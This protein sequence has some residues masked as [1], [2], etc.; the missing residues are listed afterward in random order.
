MPT[1]NRLSHLARLDSG[2]EI[3]LFIPRT[4]VIRN[5]T[6]TV[7]TT[8]TEEQ[9]KAYSVCTRLTQRNANVLRMY[10]VMYILYADASATLGQRITEG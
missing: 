1:R 9:R 7:Y 8:I 5:A 2:S 4:D 10:N 3:L 6:V